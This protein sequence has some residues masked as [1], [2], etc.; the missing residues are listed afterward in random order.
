M[1]NLKA[2]RE[3]CN[4]SEADVSRVL[5]VSE[6]T[7]KRWESSGDPKISLSQMPLFLALYG[8]EVNIEGAKEELRTKAPTVDDLVIEALNKEAWSPLW[9]RES[10][11]Y[12]TLGN[13]V[14]EL[15]IEVMRGLAVHIDNRRPVLLGQL[16]INTCADFIAT[17]GLNHIEDA[18]C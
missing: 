10:M 13:E 1:I 18:V 8:L 4:R 17:H 12:P 14:V 7:V 6:A 5:G 3:S 9:T 2:A 15:A 16:L 11:V